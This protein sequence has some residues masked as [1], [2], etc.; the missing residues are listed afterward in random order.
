M[1]LSLNLIILLLCLIALA[2]MSWLAEYI[3][4]PLLKN[5]YTVAG[6]SS[7]AIIKAVRQLITDKMAGSEGKQIQVMRVMCFRGMTLL[8]QSCLSFVTRCII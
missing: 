6:R 2:A 8:M 4:L 3:L 5:Q 7:I 1:S